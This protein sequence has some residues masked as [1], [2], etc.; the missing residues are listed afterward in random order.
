MSNGDFSILAG[1][2]WE[3]DDLKK[4]LLEKEKEMEQLKKQFAEKER[5]LNEQLAKVK[6]ELEA[7]KIGHEETKKK[8]SNAR[9][10]LLNA[11][12]KAE[13][14]GRKIRQ[15]EQEKQQQKKGFGRLFK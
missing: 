2:V 12:M 6:E 4:R 1:K 3:A 8:L 7:E 13:E 10:D 5:L 14:F 11:R 9:A 15:M